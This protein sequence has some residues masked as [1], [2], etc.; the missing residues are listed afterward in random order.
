MEQAKRELAVVALS[1]SESSPGNFSLILEDVETRRRI[2]VI[3]G[4]AEAQSIAVHMERMQPV[5]P[6]THDLYRA[7]LDALGVKLVEVLIHSVNAGVFHARLLLEKPDKSRFLLDARSSDAIAIALRM[8]API[9]AYADV[10]EEAGLLTEVFFGKNRKGSFAEYS[11]AELEELLQ[12]L[13]DKE[14]YESAVRIRDLIDRR[15]EKE[16]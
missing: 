3:I 16:G 4:Q 9:F 2:P 13:L 15:K 1:S 7:T 8:S 10:V 5:R 14:D 11:L 6:L 12:R